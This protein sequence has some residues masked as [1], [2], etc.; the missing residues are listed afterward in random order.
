MPTTRSLPQ[1]IF[2][3]LPGSLIYD[4]EQGLLG[5]VINVDGNLDS[6][7]DINR[8]SDRIRITIDRWQQGEN[9]DGGE[10]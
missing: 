10:S 2:N 4:D 6:S 1:V 7:I 3:H 9:G 8:L 5:R